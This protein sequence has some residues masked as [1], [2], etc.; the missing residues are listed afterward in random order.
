MKARWQRHYMKGENVATGDS[1]G[2]HVTK[3]KLKTPKPPLPG[4]GG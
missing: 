2:T 3:R 1:A 4:L